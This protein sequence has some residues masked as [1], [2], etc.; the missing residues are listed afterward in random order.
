MTTSCGCTGKNAHLKKVWNPIE[1]DEH[2]YGIPLT[3]NQMALIDKED[4][5]KVKS[6]SWRAQFHK[7]RGVFYAV[8]SHGLMHRFLINPPK[9][10][11]TDH[12]DRNTLNNRKSNLRIC[13]RTQN[14]MNR[15][16]QKN[17]G[18]GYKGIAKNQC[19][20]F[21]ARIVVNKKA[22]YLGTYKAPE[23]ASQAYIDA[24][25]ELQGDFFPASE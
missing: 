13:T 14:N 8:G 9:G 3:Q 24:A 19:G 16:M 21:F 23:K 4:L 17:N 22:K 5:D 2:T 10:M 1:I 11:D 15:P 25:K 7:K 18:T 20:N 12:K 6:I